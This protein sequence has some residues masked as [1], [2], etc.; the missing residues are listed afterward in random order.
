MAGNLH[1]QG[2]IWIAPHG[3]CRTSVA[4]AGEVSARSAVGDVT[5]PGG[6]DAAVDLLPGLVVVGAGIVDPDVAVWRVSV[7]LSV[8]AGS[9][10]SEGGVQ[11]RVDS[12][13]GSSGDGGLVDPV[14]DDG[15]G[16]DVG[17]GF[18]LRR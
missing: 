6:F 16:E 10:A 4:D 11:R 1:Y 14:P 7:E 8:L 13:A 12:G 17:C 9:A 2:I 18:V 5:V 3:A 15:L